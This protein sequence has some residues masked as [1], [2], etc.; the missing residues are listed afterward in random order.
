MM[1]LIADGNYGG[2]LAVD[3]RG[4]LLVAGHLDSSSQSQYNVSVEVSDGHH[5]LLTQVNC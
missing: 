1:Y 3:T 2:L 4:R 5:K